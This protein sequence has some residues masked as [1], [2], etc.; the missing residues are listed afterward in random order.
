MG[1]MVNLKRFKKRS[2]RERSAREAEA[3]RVRFGR[4]KSERAAEAGRARRAREL[5]DQHQ[6]DRRDA[7]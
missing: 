1:D 2:E 5:L 6:I 3:N 4:T 7:P